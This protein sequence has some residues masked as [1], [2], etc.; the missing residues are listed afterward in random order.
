MGSS[1]LN[2]LTQDL[3]ATIDPVAYLRS[4]G[5]EPYEWQETALSPSLRRTIILAARQSGK[6]TIT[7][8][9]GLYTLKHYARSLVLV[10]APS[11]DQAGILMKK[12]EDL[13][14]D[15]KTLPRLSNDASLSKEFING[16]RIIAL[17][18]TERAVRGYSG[19][20]MIIMD[21]ASRILD[22]TYKAVR[23]MMTGADTELVLMSTPFGK[24]GF[25]YNEWEYGSG[26]HKVLVR[27]KYT[28]DTDNK[29][30]EDIPEDEFRD[31][32]KARGVLAFY[33]PRHTRKFLQEELDSIGPY[34]FRQE[35]LCDF[36]DPEESFF[37]MALV[38]K[39]FSGDAKRLFGT[40]DDMSGFIDQGVKPLEL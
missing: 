8:N 10:V 17:P 21:E 5:V 1:T 14:W 31:M 18:G 16:S 15:D 28:L 19:P 39:A 32:W 40:R 37:N 25:F 6:S 4:L 11:Q 34:W 29:L 7:S 26:W 3:S 2:L 36:L 30:I 23:P 20:K 22:E 38:D 9:K 35:Y 27:P 24:R 13:M 12:V 33:S